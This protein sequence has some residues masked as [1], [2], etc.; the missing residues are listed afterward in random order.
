MK[1]LSEN[2]AFKVITTIIKI[3]IVIV[4]VGFILAVCLQ[5]FSDNKISIFKYRMFTVISGSMKPE[6]DMGD[7]LIS[8]EVNPSSIKVGDAISYEGKVG[9]FKNK[10]IT[11]Q[12]IEIGTDP[13]T[14]K[15]LFHTRGL[16]NPI[17]DP[18]V[19]EDQLYGVII[20]KSLLLSTIYRIIETNIGFYLFIIIPLLYII[21]SEIIMFML[22]KEEKRRSN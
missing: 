14:G 17:E 16:A 2:K 10:V 6:Y 4:L 20:Y 5:R 13:D 18:I 15:Y 21:S 7:V 22:D 19:S 8:K 1:N 9:E 3:F 11:H 12:V